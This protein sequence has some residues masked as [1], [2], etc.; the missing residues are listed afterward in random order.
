MSLAIRNNNSCAHAFYSTY[1]RCE[2]PVIPRTFLSL[3]LV[4]SGAELFL[5]P[6][7]A[8]QVKHVYVTPPKHLG[9]F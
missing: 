1:F 9:L 6:S 4:I 8:P 3:F 7:E 2:V 5:T